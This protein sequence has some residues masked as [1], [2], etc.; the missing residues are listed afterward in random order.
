MK[1][2]H[3][4]Y[5]FGT[6]AERLEHACMLFE[7]AP[8]ALEYEGDSP[9]ITT[10]LMTWLKTHAIDMDWLFAGS[11]SGILKRETERRKSEGKFVEHC[12]KMEPEVRDGFLVLMQAVIWHDLPMK[13]AHAVFAQV[14]AEFRANRAVEA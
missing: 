7:I 8:P 2:S 4:H 12:E 5:E 3:R 11:P 1:S 9:E 10:P 14:A 13:E 6:F